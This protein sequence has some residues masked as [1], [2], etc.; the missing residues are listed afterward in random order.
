MS[1]SNVVHCDIVAE[2]INRAG[3]APPAFTTTEPE[4]PTGVA[5]TIVVSTLPRLVALLVLAPLSARAC[6]TAS[7]APAAAAEAA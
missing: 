4:L 6:R 5:C 3:T 1:G 7:G 2:A